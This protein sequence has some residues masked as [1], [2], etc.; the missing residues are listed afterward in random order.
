MSRTYQTLYF[1][2]SNFFF[3]I[4]SGRVKSILFSMSTVVLNNA[5]MFLENGK[6]KLIYKQKLYSFIDAHIPY[7][8]FAIPSLEKKWNFKQ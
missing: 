5:Y 3:I 6:G 1:C 2:W 7:M 8:V 4:L